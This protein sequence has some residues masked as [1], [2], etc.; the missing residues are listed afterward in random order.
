M[1]TDDGMHE[2][3]IGLQNKRVESSVLL[4]ADQSMLSI[5]FTVGYHTR[6]KFRR[7]GDDEKTKN[8]DKT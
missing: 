5:L 6:G 2:Y 1:W 4:E 3:N 8:Q 7:Q